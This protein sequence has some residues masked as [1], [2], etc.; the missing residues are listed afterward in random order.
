M[1]LS[2]ITDNSIPCLQK[3][4]KRFSPYVT[5]VKQNTDCYIACYK[6]EAREL[7]FLIIYYVRLR[8]VLFEGRERRFFVFC[9]IG[10]LR[11]I[12]LF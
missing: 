7:F 2:L 10:F 3:K 9:F 8:Q 4:I 11:F 12:L 5:K 6:R 1:P